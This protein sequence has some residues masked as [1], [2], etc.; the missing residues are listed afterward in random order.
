MPVDHVRYIDKT[1]A[2]YATQGY[3]KPYAWSH[4][5]TVPFSP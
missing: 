4:F 3:D 5:D 2:Y 1:T